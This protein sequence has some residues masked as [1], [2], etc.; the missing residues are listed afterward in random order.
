MFAGTFEGDGQEITG[1]SINDPTATCQG[2]FGGVSGVIKN[3]TVAGSV[4]ARQYV[5]GISGYATGDAVFEYVT[6]QADVTSTGTDAGGI[7]GF[8]DGSTTTGVQFNV[9]YNEASVTGGNNYTGGIAGRVTSQ[10][11]F[12][13]CQNRG[14]VKGAGTHV[15]G[16]VGMVSSSAAAPAEL[17]NCKNSGIVENTGSNK[18]FTAGIVGQANSGYVTLQSCYNEEDGSVTGS[19]TNTAGIIGNAGTCATIVDCANLGSVSQTAGKTPTG[20]VIGTL[21]ADALR[22]E[23]CYNAGAVTGSGTYTGGVLGQTTGAVSKNYAVKYCWNEGIVVSEG[24]YLGGVAGYVDGSFQYASGTKYTYVSYCYNAGIVASGNANTYVG[25]ISG[26]NSTG[27]TGL[28]GYCISC[29]SA[30][31][32][33][34]ASEEKIAAISG[35]NFSYNEDS[36]YLSE[37]GT[38]KIATASVSAATI[39]TE[40]ETMEAA[41]SVADG[42]NTQSIAKLDFESGKAAYLLDGGLS[43][44]RKGVWAQGNGYPVF[45]DEAHRPVYKVTAAADNTDMPE[46]LLNAITYNGADA[47]ELYIAKGTNLV[48]TVSPADGYPLDTYSVKNSNGGGVDVTI[49]HGDGADSNLAFTTPD[50]GADLTVNVGFTLLPE[51]LIRIA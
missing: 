29:Y 27:G 49:T 20:G 43:G 33:I 13:D 24:T 7:V 36:Y 28:Y 10:S 51:N 8:V 9:C 3:L 40:M 14:T 45:A 46:G 18:N 31:T 5:G 6:N 50:S 30:G 23:R 39:K 41:A 38:Y 2:F 34:G 17:S 44:E 19:G 32:I 11:L 1:L 48:L 4:S 26:R 22:V 12:N 21:G 25:G 15:A 35:A 47:G 16:I 42:A 37:K